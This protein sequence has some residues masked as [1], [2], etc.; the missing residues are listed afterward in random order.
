[1]RDKNRLRTVPDSAGRRRNGVTCNF[2]TLGSLTMLG[3]RRSDASR[4]LWKRTTD[5][6][7]F[8]SCRGP[9]DCYVNWFFG[10]FFLASFNLTVGDFNLD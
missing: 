4:S 9:R 3:G 10:V 1:M 6:N 2:E 8:S 5:T 7:V